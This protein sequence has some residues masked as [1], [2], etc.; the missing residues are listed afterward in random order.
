VVFEPAAAE[1]GV[2][3]SLP[4]GGSRPG[5]LRVVIV[6][7]HAML[8]MGTRQILSAED[9][10]EV[11][12][13]AAD[14]AEALEA[15][16]RSAPDLVLVDIRLPD[17]NGI[18]LARSI[19]ELSP[20]TK[21]VI[22]SAYD[23]EDYVRAAL[24]AGVVGYLLKTMP[25]DEL[26]RAVSA[27]ASGIMVLDPSVKTSFSRSRSRRDDD[28]AGALASLTWRERQVVDLVAEGLANKTVATQ[29]GI[30]T[31]T[32]EGHLNHAFVKLGVTSR[33]ELVRLALRSADAER[34]A[35]GGGVPRS[36]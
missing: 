6:D 5:T 36:T 19:A 34:G 30:S 24:D 23:D 15:V 18:E 7:D 22:L 2:L 29:L 1:P 9:D 25:G 35:A 26:V 32:V 11:V 4:E 8:R 21:V 17:R 14:A 28:P 12:A 13:E 3:G 33:T 10:I 20:E 16:A 27:A 31:R